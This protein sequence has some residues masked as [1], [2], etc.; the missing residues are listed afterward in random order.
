VRLVLLIGLVH[1]G[2]PTV[3]T[4]SAG[5]FLGRLLSLKR[6]R[7]NGLP[8]EEP[9]ST[10]PFWIRICLHRLRRGNQSRLCGGL[11]R[12]GGDRN[13]RDSH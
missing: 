11:D 8:P 5:I 3:D 12:S 2:A 10:L 1:M 9:D 7:S 4:R 13:S 6:S